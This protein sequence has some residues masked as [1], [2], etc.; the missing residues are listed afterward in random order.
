M[1]GA[2]EKQSDRQGRG[3]AGNRRNN[4]SGADRLAHR[5]TDR[6]GEDRALDRYGNRHDDRQADGAKAQQQTTALDYD[7]A[8]RAELAGERP[9]QQEKKSDAADG[10]RLRGQSESAQHD[11]EE[12][13]EIEQQRHW[14]RITAG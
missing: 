8:S 1:G 9:G 4:E 11:A 10:Q 7:L 2:Q 12:A 14:R 13:E 6:I 5:Q 3:N